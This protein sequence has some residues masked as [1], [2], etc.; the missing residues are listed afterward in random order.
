MG[1]CNTHVC[2]GTDSSFWKTKI[3]MILTVVTAREKE[4]VPSHVYAY[5]CAKQR[6]SL[7]PAGLNMSTILTTYSYNIDTYYCYMTDITTSLV[8]RDTKTLSSEQQIINFDLNIYL[9]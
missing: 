2:V 3:M 4:N 6:C 7:S 5:T 1:E 9:A 8:T